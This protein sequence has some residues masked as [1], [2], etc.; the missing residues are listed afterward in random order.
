MADRERNPPDGSDLEEDNEEPRARRRRA[1]V[2]DLLRLL[3][4]QRVV[5]REREAANGND[6]LVSGLKRSGMLSR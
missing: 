2:V 4:G 3:A 5:V 1:E 6:E